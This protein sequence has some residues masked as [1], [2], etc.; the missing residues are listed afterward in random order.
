MGKISFVKAKRLVTDW[1]RATLV[2]NASAQTEQRRILV[3][4]ERRANCQCQ[5]RM[6]RFIR[7]QI[8]SL[9]SL[10]VTFSEV[11]LEFPHARSNGNVRTLWGATEDEKRWRPYRIQIER[12]RH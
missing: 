7:S 2:N 5:R 8:Y 3:F 11:V 4:I 9:A 1:A 12:L 10:I 6:A